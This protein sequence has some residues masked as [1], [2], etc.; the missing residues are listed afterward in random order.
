MLKAKAGR[1]D[2]N[3]IEGMICAGGCVR[4]NGTMVN[5]KNTPLHLKQYCEAS[6]RKTLKSL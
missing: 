5:K 2:G 6:A 3:F 4:G 1:L